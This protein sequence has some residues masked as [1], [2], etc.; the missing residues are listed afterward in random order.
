ME[1]E[2]QAFCVDSDGS[3]MQL[4]RVRTKSFQ[5]AFVLEIAKEF[6]HNANSI[7]LTLN[8]SNVKTILDDLDVEYKLALLEKSPQKGSLLAMYI[9]LARLNTKAKEFYLVSN[10]TKY[11]LKFSVL[12]LFDANLKVEDCEISTLCS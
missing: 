9:S 1:S 7:Y 8:N 11:P 5:E 2:V 6:I 10:N 12:K 4:F 3:T